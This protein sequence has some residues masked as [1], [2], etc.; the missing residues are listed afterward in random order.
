MVLSP[1]HTTMW[2][3]IADCNSF[4]FPFSCF[5]QKVTIGVDV[6][7][8]KVSLCKGHETPW[9][10]ASQRLPKLLFLPSSSH[11]KELNKHKGLQALFERCNIRKL[12]FLN[13]SFSMHFHGIN[14]L[15]F[16][17][18]MKTFA[19]RFFLHKYVARSRS[20]L[21]THTHIRIRDHTSTHGNVECVFA[22]H[23]ITLN[24]TQF[25]GEKLCS[26]SQPCADWLEHD[27]QLLLHLPGR[28][29]LTRVNYTQSL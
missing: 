11:G 18:I 26:I 21:H 7:P 5:V 4:Y 13:W 19:Y 9:D 16:W 24:V 15:A 27:P 17:Q 25:K 8:W 14:P 28:F 22:W 12:N 1:G 29:H 3:P 23:V 10:R 6:N 2:L 20:V